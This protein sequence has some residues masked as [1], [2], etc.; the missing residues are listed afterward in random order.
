MA[1]YALTENITL[2]LNVN[3]VFAEDYYSIN[4]NGGRYL[5]GEPRTYSLTADFSW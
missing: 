5:P 1:A 2:R 3:N 4:N